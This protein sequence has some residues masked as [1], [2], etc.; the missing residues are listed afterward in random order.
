VDNKS[1]TV[2]GKSSMNWLFQCVSIH[3]VF[4]CIH[5]FV[6]VAVI[7]TICLVFVKDCILALL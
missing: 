1:K 7:S 6:S 2:P 5:L 4:T 3:A